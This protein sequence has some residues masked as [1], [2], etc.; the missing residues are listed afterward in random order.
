MPSQV[1]FGVDIVKG[2]SRAREA[3]HYAV[4]ILNGSIEKYSSV[5]RFKLLRLI[6]QYNP[7]ILAV[8]SITELAE[9]KKE[10]VHLLRRLPPDVKLVQVT[11]NEH[12]EPLTKLGKEHGISFNPIIPEE[13]AFASASLA[14]MGVG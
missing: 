4:V 1:I 11:G 5:S 12:Q 9:N 8:D 2:S 10:L 14:S 13:E 3:P 7:C 6:K